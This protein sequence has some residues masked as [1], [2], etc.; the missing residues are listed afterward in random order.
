[1]SLPITSAAIFTH[2]RLIWFCNG[3]GRL[4]EPEQHCL[5][6]STVFVARSIHPTADENRRVGNSRTTIT[7]LITITAAANSQI[8]AET[9]A[10]DGEDQSQLERRA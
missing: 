10:Q 3:S 6:S 8:H 9:L 2:F 5:R 1:L 7:P 4:A